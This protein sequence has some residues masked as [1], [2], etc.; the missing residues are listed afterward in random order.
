MSTEQTTDAKQENN[1]PNP[2]PKELFSLARIIVMG[3]FVIMLV[4]IGLFFAVGSGNQA[5][6][7][8]LTAVLPLLGAWVGAVIAFYFSSKNLESATKSVQ[9]LVGGLTGAAKLKTVPTKDKMIK[10]D[11]MYLSKTADDTLPIAKMLSDLEAAKKGNRIPVLYDKDY[12]RYVIHRSTIDRF[13]ANKAIDEKTLSDDLKK[14]TLHDLIE[15]QP[16]LRHSFGVVK[17]DSTLA[18]VKALMDALGNQCQDVFVT[19]TGS[20]SEPV[21]GWVTNV[22]LENNSKV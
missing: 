10:K 14:L 16:G 9:N 17:E 22:I 8:I 12:P 5:S 7:T 21:L 2:D 15:N 1:Q 4:V 13:L 3:T 6:Q 19:K 20:Y 11:Q 18:D